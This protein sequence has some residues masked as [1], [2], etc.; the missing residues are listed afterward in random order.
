[1]A[2]GNYEMDGHKY[3]DETTL[4]QRNRLLD[5]YLNDIAVMKKRNKEM[6]ETVNLLTGKLKKEPLWTRLIIAMRVACHGTASLT[7]YKP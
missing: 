6:Q 1:M 2:Y 3:K 4:G 5:C 7:Q